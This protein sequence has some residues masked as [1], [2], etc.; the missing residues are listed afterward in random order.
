MVRTVNPS[1]ERP[2]EVRL[3]T[4]TSQAGIEV[5]DGA[6]HSLA[7]NIPRHLARSDGTTWLQLS[8]SRAERPA[9]STDARLLGV[10]LYRL[11]VCTE[12]SDEAKCLADEMRP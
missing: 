12:T 6:V 4:G 3:S 5:V 2:A 10:C 9:G 1:V 7:L 8:T 11:M